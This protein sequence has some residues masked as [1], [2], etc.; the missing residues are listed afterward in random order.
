MDKLTAYKTV[1]RAGIVGMVITGIGLLGLFWITPY[2]GI[3]MQDSFMFQ[4]LMNLLIVFGLSYG[5][6]KYSRICSIGLLIYF[7][8]IYGSR[9]IALSSSF[10]TK[11]YL[12]IITALCI[13][14]IYFLVQGVRGTF[15]LH[16]VED[17]KT[18]NNIEKL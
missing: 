5:I 12:H 14:V 11:P 8:I 10:K 17:I 2:I 13:V 4:G 1:R 9:I 18:D 6:F 16:Q 3:S 7:I 15:A